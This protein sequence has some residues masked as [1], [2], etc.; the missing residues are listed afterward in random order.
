MV[1]T[2]E[3]AQAID[4]SVYPAVKILFQT[5]LD[6]REFEE[7]VRWIERESVSAAR[8]DTICYATKEN[9][10][11]ARA[12]CADSEIDLVLVIGGRRSANTR[13][14]WETCR[15]LKPAYLVHTPDDLESEWLRGVSTVGITAGASTPDYAIDEIEARLRELA[16][17]VTESGEATRTIGTRAQAGATSSGGRSS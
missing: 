9:Q 7:V 1:K 3:E 15:E 12:L 17:V 8:A 4:W 2:L 11:A 6:A 14:L 13:H 5:T 10:D 16:E